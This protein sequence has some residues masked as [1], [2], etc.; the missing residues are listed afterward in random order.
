MS[1]RQLALRD[2]NMRQLDN[3]IQNKRQ[4]I[5][6]KKKELD[7]QQTNNEFLVEVHNNYKKYYDFIVKE[8]Q[9][10]L[11]ALRTLEQYLTDLSNTGNMLHHEVKT[12]KNDHAQLLGEIKQITTELDELVK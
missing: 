5:I 6:K 1:N 4:F 9:D 3:E 12:V 11:T 2:L 10:Q 8:K 7:K